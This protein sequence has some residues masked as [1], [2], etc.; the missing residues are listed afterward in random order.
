VAVYGDDAMARRL[1]VTE[2]TGA[3]A[4][5]GPPRALTA[6]MRQRRWSDA[7]WIARA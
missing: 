6:P 3:R 1:G 5:V 4:S 2:S 7:A